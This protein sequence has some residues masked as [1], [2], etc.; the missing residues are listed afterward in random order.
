VTQHKAVDEV[1]MTATAKEPVLRGDPSRPSLRTS[2]AE[3]KE[4]EFVECFRHLASLRRLTRDNLEHVEK[5]L[6]KV[7]SRAGIVDRG[8]DHR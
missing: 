1:E 3:G 2:P 7:M 6:V 5:E 8:G 4:R